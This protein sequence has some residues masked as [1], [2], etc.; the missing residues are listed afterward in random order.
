M[1][2][3]F[4]SDKGIRE[5]ARLKMGAEKRWERG[6]V[7][8]SQVGVSRARLLP[9]LSPSQSPVFAPQKGSKNYMALPGGVLVTFAQKISLREAEAWAKSQNLALEH[10]PGASLEKQTWLVQT[11]AGLESLQMANQ[12]GKKKD[13]VAASPN[14]WI[15]VGPKKAPVNGPEAQAIRQR[16]SMELGKVGKE[17]TASTNANRP[18]HP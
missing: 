2:A 11:K 15:Q 14:W 17:K 7:L 16:I 4:H 10:L 12:L 1:I 6:T 9:P 5:K 8:L 13:I 3:D 18:N